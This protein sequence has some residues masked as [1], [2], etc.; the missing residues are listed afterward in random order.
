MP[1]QGAF[2]Y[3][4]VVILSQSDWFTEMRSNRYNYAVRFSKL[5]PVYFVQKIAS[6]DDD[7]IIA[8]KEGNIT[9][10]NPIYGYTTETLESVLNLTKAINAKN[11]LFWIYTPEYADLLPRINISHTAVY[12][13]TEAY[14]NSGLMSFA[15]KKQSY[16]YLEKLKST[17]NFCSFVIAVSRGVADG[18][19]LDPEITVPVYT[20]TNGCDYSFWS[21]FE[22]P[23]K[24]SDIVLYQGGIHR[25]LDFELIFHIVKDNPLVQF[26]F[27]GEDT[28][29]TK[30]DK[31]LWSTIRAFPNFKFVGKLHPD[32][33]RELSHQAK[34]GIIP[35]RKDDWLK[36]MSFPLKAFEYL[37]SGLEV[38]STPIKALNDFS[39]QFYIA[40]GKEDFNSH[41]LAALAEFPR[42]S[43]SRDE[44]C[45]A[46]DYDLKFQNALKLLSSIQ[47]SKPL[48]QKAKKNVLL[49]YDKDSCHVNT[50]REHVNAFGLFSRHN[51]TYYSAT[52]KVGA[53]QEFV[54]SFDVVVLHYSIRISS[55]GHLSEEVYQSITGFSG[56]KV[57]LIQDEYD[58][59]ASTYKYM[60]K[61]N[62]DILF[63]CVPEKYHRYA[64]PAN[65]F[66]H[67]KFVNN[68]TGYLPYTLNRLSQIPM[69]ERVLDVFYRGRDL[70]YFY[71]SLG[72][73][74]FEIGL[75]FIKA[76]EENK[77]NVNAD[78]GASSSERIYGDAWYRAIGSSKTMLGTESGSNVF[79]FDGTL[80]NL[81]D[82]D[83]AKGH[84]Y[85]RIFKERLEKLESEVKMNQISP[86]VFEAILLKTVLILYEGEYSGIL[87]PGR[88]YIS[89]KKDFSNINEVVEAI[90]D[91]N[92][93]Q[94]IADKAYS[95]IV[96]NPKY[97]YEY[98]I[99]N[100]FDREIDDNLLYVKSRSLIP[101]A[102][103]LVNKTQQLQSSYIKYF[104]TKNEG[105][106]P[107][108]TLS[109]ESEFIVQNQ[110][111][112]RDAW[113]YTVNRGK[114]IVVFVLMLIPKDVF[115]VIVKTYRILR[116]GAF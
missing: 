47:I 76:C 5:A 11:I 3:D 64:Y 72:R 23:E 2:N 48:S 45:K 68:L 36:D 52:G 66:P 113:H 97:S 7:N 107:P 87:I 42:S 99:Q 57:L 15:S 14:I 94:E 77:L 49:L 55:P 80:K 35:F 19:K 104:V 21:D 89:L 79:D 43:E 92:R 41:I 100:V 26:V 38:V 82:E 28:V 51:I 20:I 88:H 105:Y 110:L 9:I 111:K 116:Y 17:I 83:I 78:V 37:A 44:I 84:D 102:G 73:E 101:K 40:D 86:K 114:Q 25:K 108:T 16:P 32:G 50:I 98:F 46:Q 67:I 33:V 29:E 12:H 13:A 34:V 75:K 109:E 4:A 62:F 39:E 31:D 106:V 90:N 59:L 60:S 1:N 91:N 58:N 65:L 18:I 69:S 96:Q 30:E 71:G 70:P 95:E 24:R 27:C 74:K 112:S 115:N 81:I 22:S 56:L 63:T 6:K 85:N 8:G 10:V 54:K 61:I 93:L 103:Y 53:V